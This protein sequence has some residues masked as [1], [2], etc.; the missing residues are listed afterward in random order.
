MGQ[1]FLKIRAHSLEEAYARMRKQYG[2]HALVV[3]TNQ[4]N[5]G[6]ILGFFGRKLVEVT[7][8]VPDTGQPGLPNPGLL[9]ST[10]PVSAAER[11]YGATA[12]APREADGKETVQYFEK[13]V[14]DAQQRMNRQAPASQNTVQP[15]LSSASPDVVPFP[16]AKK[17]EESGQEDVHRELQEIR[18]MMQ[19]IYTENPGAGL[20]AEFAPHY[21]TLIDRGVSRKVAAVL[22][23]AVIKNS[24]LSI[25]RDA[26]VFVERLKLEVQKTLRVNGGI[27]LQAGHPRVVALVGATGV[28]KTTNLAKLAAR[29]AVHERAQVALITSD[30]Y[31]IAASDQLKVYAGIIGLPMRVVNDVKEMGEALKAFSGYDLILLDTAGG[32]QFNLE[33]IRELQGLLYAARPHETILVMGAGTPLND[34]RDATNN[35]KSLNPTSVLF[36]KLD[37]T[38]Q[39]GAMYSLLVEAGLPLSYLSIG[40][41]VPDDLRL[42]TPSMVANL[43]LEGNTSRG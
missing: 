6:G 40:Q 32:S 35:F 39:Y 5:E 27:A 13:I 11:K 26:R 33:Q 21:R 8:S 2:E 15:P 7:A 28:G 25:L 16:K 24:D 10:R 41:N 14:R 22:I 30:T 19:V 9:R 34:L 36:S 42:A 4:V 29:Y 43:L 12:K 3:S 1:K 23:G 31:R 18:E 17:T 37:E 20:P 38:Q